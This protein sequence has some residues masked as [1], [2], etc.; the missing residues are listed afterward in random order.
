MLVIT[1]IKC[2]ASA[3][4]LGILPVVLFLTGC[5]DTVN[6]VNGSGQPVGLLVDGQDSG[7]QLNDRAFVSAAS[8]LNVGQLSSSPQTN[9]VIGFTNDRPPKY[10][11]APWTSGSDAFNVDFRPAIGIPVTV[12]IVKGPFAEQRQHAIEACIRTSAIWHNERM[13]II[14][15][16]FNI[17]DA[18]A[19]PQA[20]LHYA[21]P[22]GDVGDVVWKPLR[23]D[24]GFVAGQ[25]NIYWLDT[26]NGGTGSGWSNFGAQIAMG[27]NSGDELLSHEIGHAFSL[28]HVD[29]DSNFNVDN[30]MHSASNTRQYST[31]GQLFRAHLNPSSILNVLYSARLGEVTRSCSYSNTA[32]FLCPAIQKRV[33]A[34]GGFPPN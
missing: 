18:T 8:P 11:S 10:L 6:V 22:N 4:A 16:P 25:L 19:D 31:E 14:F 1:P 5:N 32:T 27:K 3:L 24:I 34:D 28:T 17:I 2:R 7:G 21:F 15:T 23:D 20:P 29:S 12:W 13:G 26:V 33:W 30:I 9:E